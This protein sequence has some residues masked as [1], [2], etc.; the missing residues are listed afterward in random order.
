MQAV[1]KTIFSG[2]KLS[3]QGWNLTGLFTA[4]LGQAAY[5][6][7]G[8]KGFGAVAAQQHADDLRVLGPSLHAL[9]QGQDHRQGEGV[10]GLWRI[11]AGDADASAATAG[12]FFEMQVHR[13]LNRE[14]E[15]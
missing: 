1:V 4:R 3:S 6:A 8:A 11:Q 12:Q 5:F 2:E 10:K 7:T 15:G 9:I 14:G 13:D